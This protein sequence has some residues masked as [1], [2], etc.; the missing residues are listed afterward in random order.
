MLGVF[1]AVPSAKACFLA[2][3]GGNIHAAAVRVLFRDIEIQDDTRMLNLQL[4]VPAAGPVAAIMQNPSRYA[5]AVRSITIVD[6]TIFTSTDYSSSSLFSLDEDSS[7][8][9]LSKAL[10]EKDLQPLATAQLERILR[11]T[12][13]LESFNWKATTLPPDGICEVCLLGPDFV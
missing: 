6:P 13:N 5:A 10:T 12:R 4:G 9:D 3:C 7:S 2:E 11:V 1:N 8:E